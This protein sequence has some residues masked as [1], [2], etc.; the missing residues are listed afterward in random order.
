VVTH[1][2]HTLVTALVTWLPTSFP[3]V[4][5]LVL[6]GCSA[7]PE[8]VLGALSP[9]WSLASLQLGD[10]WGYT[11][12]V[13]PGSRWQVT[14]AACQQH[15]QPQVQ[16][17]QQKEEGVGQV[18]EEGA[19]QQQQQQQ[20][21]QVLSVSTAV[22]G[23]RQLPS[24]NHHHHIQQQQQQSA[25]APEDDPCTEP[26]A[27]AAA[28]P[29]NAAS[30]CL[31]WSNLCLTRLV[32]TGAA[33]PLG[34]PPK[35]LQQLLGT[36]ALQEGLPAPSSASAAGGRPVSVAHSSSSSSWQ[37]QVAGGPVGHSSNAAGGSHNSSR[38]SGSSSSR[39]SFSSWAPPGAGL[40]ACRHLRHLELTGLQLG[41]WR[42][43]SHRQRDCFACQVRLC[44]TR[45]DQ[46]IVFMPCPAAEGGGGAVAGGVG[47]EGVGRP[48][49]SPYCGMM[50]CSTLVCMHPT[51]VRMLRVLQLLLVVLCGHTTCAVSRC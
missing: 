15:Q 13:V 25:T 2:H 14:G 48:D 4:R 47:S 17:Q 12:A 26:P 24:V 5:H 35:G 37:Q 27:E 44:L 45:V 11:G 29:S 19:E 31:R 22:P 38:S 46:I 18:S 42:C 40:A 32:V 30:C 36:C 43:R 6:L 3:A 7:L 20:Q 9:H 34:A 8:G 10:A 50:F 28:A 41:A 49:M 16:Q 21:Q 51:L 23:L 33:L 1:Y 39:V